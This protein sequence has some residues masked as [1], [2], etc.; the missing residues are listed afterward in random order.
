VPN[1]ELLVDQ[2][3]NSG[4]FQVT[5]D[6][7]FKFPG[8]ELSPEQAT[9]VF[10]FGIAALV[11]VVLLIVVQFLPLFRRNPQ[12]SADKPLPSEEA[13]WQQWHTR[14][15]QAMQAGDYRSAAHGWYLSL[16]LW[17]DHEKRV[18]YQPTRTNFEYLQDLT[19]E[20][21]LQTTLATLI[22]LY[23]PLWYGEQPGTAAD[24]LACQALANQARRGR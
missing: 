13:T 7:P 2:L 24:A 11:G 14:A 1:V 19:T 5:E 8:L 23:E 16:V 12:I 21:Q 22:K 18:R 15:E 17:L 6:A 3:R 9:V 10:W 20:P 4:K